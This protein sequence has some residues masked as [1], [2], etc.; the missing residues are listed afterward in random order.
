[1]TNIRWHSF[2]SVIETFFNRSIFLYFVRVRI[3]REIRKGLKSLNLI[4]VA[5]KWNYENNLQLKGKWSE[6]VATIEEREF[7]VSPVFSLIALVHE[8]V[9]KVRFDFYQK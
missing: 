8:T 1:M 6:K 5:I 3:I 2:I 4:F 7:P 9:R